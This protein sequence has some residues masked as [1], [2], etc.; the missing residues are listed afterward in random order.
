MSKYK[1]M[2]KV[3][4][5]G[6]VIGYVTDKNNVEQVIKE[7]IDNRD[8]NIAFVDI[9]EKPEYEFCLVDW[10]K[11]DSTDVVL[12]K[13]K[14]ES[15]ITYK[16]YAIKLNNESQQYVSTVEDAEQVVYELKEKFD[17]ELDLNIGI[18]E[19]YKTDLD[20]INSIDMQV[21]KVNLDTKILENCGSA[22]DGI[23]LSAPI[24][25]SVTSRFGERW[26][27]SHTGLD[28]GAST[29]TPIYACSKGTIT[30]AGW[31]SGYG[32]LVIVDHGN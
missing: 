2:Y 22:I 17:G 16:L 11:N 6:E 30:F 23:V 26:G 27:R 31:N 19:I 28:I 10:N 32:Y 4:I 21:A 1:P 3:T 18:E 15:E 24:S 29:G 8:G 9:K 12:Q 25:G 20:N 5:A 7:Y 14:D 13:I